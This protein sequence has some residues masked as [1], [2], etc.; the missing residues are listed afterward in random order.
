MYNSNSDY[1]YFYDDFLNNKKFEIGVNRI[2]TRLLELSLNGRKEKLTILKN[3]EEIVKDGIKKGAKTVVAIGNDA[4]ISKV[5]TVMADFSDVVLGMIPVGPDQ[6]IAKLLGI[7]VG[8]AAC[9]VLSKRVVKKVDLGKVN[10][11]YFLFS[12]DI[13]FPQVRV[14]CDNK[15]QLSTEGDDDTLHI[16][17]LGGLSSADL[18]AGRNSNPADGM[19]EAIVTPRRSSWRVFGRGYNRESI[20]T[21]KKATIDSRGEAASLLA[22]GQTVV[23]TPATIEVVPKKL[24]II[25]GRDRQ[26]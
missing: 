10:D 7:P 8:I 2:E 1:F 5:M 9:D 18:P 23:K 17:N 24:R 15:Y 22:D 12:V 25:V 4:T 26:F 11:Q 16:C 14:K 3:T 6:N 20:F 19:L 13:P 21:I